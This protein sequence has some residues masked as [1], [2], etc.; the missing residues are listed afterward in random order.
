VIHIIDEQGVSQLRRKVTNDL[1]AIE[2][3]LKPSQGKLTGLVVKSTY[4]WH[5]LVDRLMDAGFKAHLANTTAIQQY[6]G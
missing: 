3:L 5:W 6:S 1:V 2:R 4:N